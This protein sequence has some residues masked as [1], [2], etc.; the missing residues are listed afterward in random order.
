MRLERSASMSVDHSG[1]TE[2]V[3]DKLPRPGAADFE[4][5][6]FVQTIDGSYV[7]TVDRDYT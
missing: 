1:C 3:H 5:Y 4:N 6:V 2:N 7:Q